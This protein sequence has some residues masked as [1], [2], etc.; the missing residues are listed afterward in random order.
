M[1]NGASLLLATKRG[2][3]FDYQVD[4]GIVDELDEYRRRHR[5]ELGL[6]V[7]ENDCDV[8]AVS[9][10]SALVATRPETFSLGFAWGGAHDEV[11]FEAGLGDHRGFGPQRL[12]GRIG[13]GT[14]WKRNRP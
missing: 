12:L 5:L 2:K 4:E 3:R 11:A 6:Y 7:Q 10:L 1:F 14:A 9:L 8:E 13:V